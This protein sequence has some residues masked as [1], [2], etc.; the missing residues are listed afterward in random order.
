MKP[1]V[2]AGPCPL[3]QCMLAGISCLASVVPAGAAET[4][5]VSPY[6]TEPCGTDAF[7]TSSYRGLALKSFS[8]HLSHLID[9]NKADMP[10]PYT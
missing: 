3:Q 1:F 2:S 6:G 8:S 9:I 7:I 5:Q 4:V 10:C